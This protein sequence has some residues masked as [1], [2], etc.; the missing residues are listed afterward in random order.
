MNTRKIGT[1]TVLEF[2]ACLPQEGMSCE[3]GFSYKVSVK[4]GGTG[5]KI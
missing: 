4:E 5:V 2:S 3:C 1:G